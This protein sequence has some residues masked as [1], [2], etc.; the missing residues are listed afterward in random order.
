MIKDILSKN[1]KMD[2]QAL[3]QEIRGYCDTLSIPLK[4]TENG[5]RADMKKSSAEGPIC[6]T[7][8]AEINQNGELCFGVGGRTIEHRDSDWGKIK[9]KL[10][11]QKSVWYDD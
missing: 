3:L 5:V 2:N 10:Y 8:Y 7:F 6:L 1:F 11:A 9:E 4:E